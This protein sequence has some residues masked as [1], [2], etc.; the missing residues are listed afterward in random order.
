MENKKNKKNKKGSAVAIGNFDGF[1]LGHQK[2]IETL[3]RIAI[4][5]NLIS[6]ILTFIP[7]PKVYFNTGLNL[8]NSEEQKKQ[9]MEKLGVDNIVLLNFDEILN[10][11]GETFVKDILIDKFNVKCVVMGQNFKFGK[12][13]ENDVESLKKMGEKFG[14][15]YTI[16]NPV[17]L[18]GT[19]I[20]SSL[21]RKKLVNAEIETSNRMLGRLYYI[22]GVIKE[23][24]KIGRQL[25]FP[26]INIKTQNE[27]LPEGVFKTRTQIDQQEQIYDSITYIG[28]SPTFSGKEKKVE[29][30]ILNF[31][32]SVYGNKVRLYFE[33]KLRDEIR[34]D[35]KKNLINQIKKD[36][37]RLKVDKGAFF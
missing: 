25:G 7:N 17:I 6:M 28:S 37:R 12:N 26:T 10:M 1:H 27:I 11:P 34:F 2:L 31:D 35:S 22:D 20:S 5:K 29:T 21:I 4:E 15:E 3:K 33:K 24:D 8:I 30:H 32:K 9:I 23:G 13:R 18:N 36:I 16:V 19:P 14:F